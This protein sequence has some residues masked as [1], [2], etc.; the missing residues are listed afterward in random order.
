MTASLHRQTSVFISILKK[1][2]LLFPVALFMLLTPGIP[3]SQAATQCSLFNEKFDLLP[4]N[5]WTYDSAV[6]SLSANVIKAENVPSTGSARASADFSPHGNYILD[7]D[8]TLIASSTDIDGAYGIAVYPASGKFFEIGNKKFSVITVMFFYNR[9]LARLYGLDSVT[10]QWVN[11]EAANLSSAATAVGISFG[12]G[13]VTLRLNKQDTAIQMAVNNSQAAAA[14]AKLELRAQKAGTQVNFDNVCAGPLV[15]TPTP[16]PQTMPMPASQEGFFYQASELPSKNATPSLAKPI[17][18]GSVANKGNAYSLK[19]DTGQFAGPVDLYLVYLYSAKYNALYLID[20]NNNLTQ[21][22]VPW[23]TAV[24]SATGSLFGDVD[25]SSWPGET[26]Y[27]ALLAVPSGG[28]WSSYYFWITAFDINGKVEISWLPDA[29]PPIIIKQKDVQNVTIDNKT[30]ISGEYLVTITS[31]AQTSGSIRITIP[32]EESLLPAGWNQASFVPEYFDAATNT[33]KT[34]GSFIIY[35]ASA[36]T[37][38][39]S[40]NIVES[41][42]LQANI[43]SFSMQYMRGPDNNWFCENRY[44]VTA[45]GFS[46]E[47]TVKQLPNS[48]FIFHY[49][50]AQNFAPNA[51]NIVP[52]NWNGTDAGYEAPSYIR[53]LDDVLNLV[54]RRLVGIVDSNGNKLLPE[55][56]IP[57]H[58]YM[59]NLG[60]DPGDSKIG[61]PLRISTKNI[62]SVADMSN[63][64][65]HE[66]FH[67]FQGYVLGTVVSNNAN[68]LLPIRWFLEATANYYSALVNNLDDSEKR[69]LYLDRFGTDYLSVPISTDEEQSFYALAY[70][71]DWISTHYGN[72]AIIGDVL[73]DVGKTVDPLMSLDSILK[74]NNEPSGISGAFDKY[75]YYLLT[76]PNGFGSA[77]YDIKNNMHNYINKNQG[78]LLTKQN[79]F[80]SLDRWIYMAPLS[81]IYINISANA[82]SNIDSLMIIDSTR[83]SSTLVNVYT[84]D[85]YGTNNNDYQGKSP[86]D[87]GL[88]FPYSAAKQLTIKNF[89]SMEQM[90]VNLQKDFATEGAT[91]R[92]GMDYYLLIKPEVKQVGEGAV[93]WDTSSVGNIPATYIKG[94]DVYKDMGGGNYTQL[95]KKKIALEVG[96]E[97]A[98]TCLTLQD[99]N[100]VVKYTD[101]IVVVIEDKYGNKWPEINVPSTYT[102][103]AS[104]GTGGTISPSSATVNSGKTASFTVTP[105]TGYSIASV[106]GCGGTLKG[107]TYTTGAITADCTVSASFG[108]LTDSCCDENGPSAAAALASCEYKFW[109]DAPSCKTWCTAYPSYCQ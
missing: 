92:I 82:K 47:I 67:V 18:V 100:D 72:T 33:W 22:I 27:V 54:F 70:F 25:V 35:D 97:Q 95:N 44:R 31:T 6:W 42:F 34:T 75:I 74:K 37:L 38:S 50:E 81:A 16:V 52:V 109:K 55:I 106:T 5:G 29:L 41:D 28:D 9:S 40:V 45:T 24:T 8:T 88:S 63:V 89:K 107:N 48:N 12:A 7:V 62:E 17:G 98:I 4:S 58:V 2:S 71:F 68:Q 103:T 21:A 102:V 20:S 96:A 65:G 3:A 26:Y 11:T 79:T 61:G 77:N 15:V 101:K 43:Q 59:Q 39:F 108:T 53:H 83:S 69:N 94:Y 60:G 64:A 78:F 85:F 1:I 10:S 36:K 99:C 84:F 86:I 76:H 13:T 51:S 49:Y 57:Q 23:R 73:L 87:N 93:V 32:I 105:S 104:A 14:T 46:G 91:D 66:L 80:V 19:V 90:F 30:V 56:S